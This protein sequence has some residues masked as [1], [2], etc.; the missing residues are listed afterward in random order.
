MADDAV[1]ARDAG[2]LGDRLERADLVVGVHDADQHRP[3][4][5]RPAHVLGVHDPEAVDG[6]DGQPITEA[7]F[8]VTACGEDRRMLDRRGD[9]VVAA[10][11]EAARATPLIARLSASL[12]LAVKT[13]LV[14]LAAEQRRDLRARG[15][16]ARWATAPYL[17]ALEG[18]PNRSSRYGRIASRTSGAIGVVAL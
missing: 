18:L 13:T 16:T 8:E 12:P 1:L 9:D 17:C 10:R 11:R 3:G 15:S 4:L 6:H 7:A 2:D 5:D 14:R